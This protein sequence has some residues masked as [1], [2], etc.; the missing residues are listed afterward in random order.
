MNIRKPEYYDEFVCTAD[1]CP[2]TC[3]REWKI[4]VDD[5]TN[6]KWKEL[7]PPKE[8]HP[9][10]KNLS[11]YTGKKD[12]ARV[13]ALNKK[14][15]CPFL[16]E[17]KLCR[18]VC[19]YG[20]DVL[21]ETC[22]VFPRE[23]HTFQDRKEF[24][25]MPSCPAVIDLMR[26]YPDCK[27]LE[28]TIIEDQT[29]QTLG[30]LAVENSKNPSLSQFEND[31]TTDLT[32]EGE[33]MILR[34]ARSIFS[35]WM[36]RKEY[37]PSENLKHIFFAALEL[38]RILQEK[39]SYSKVL[40]DLDEYKSTKLQKQLAD[41]IEKIPSDSESAF[42]EQNELFLD[43]TANYESEGLY[44]AELSY[45]I[46]QANK[47]E[48]NDNL[49]STEFAKNKTEF[50]ADFSNWS[51]LMRCFLT[52]E[53]ESDCLLPEG[54]MQD[55]L[56][57]LEWIALEYATIKH[58]LFLDRLENGKLTYERVRSAVV[59]ICRMTGYEEDDIYE[60]LEDSFEDVI[61]EWGYLALILS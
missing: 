44:Q 19:T 54:N 23:V 26:K 13:I 11:Q 50:E 15:L 1:R 18:L 29:E 4:G 16:D 38:Q 47:L 6:Q 57:H 56:V 35:D 25:L 52:A 42:Y 5:L 51:E 39:Q 48:E 53:I 58:F 12:G 45:A 43:L 46:D 22:R 59:L 37:T 8:V 49:Y 61:W 41:A 28:N 40:S 20:D 21:S 7:K 9:V 55:F 24:F 17:K 34:K 14:H 36:R 32:I 30:Q 3:C 10:R 33:L 27:Y 60:Y 2:M 31:N